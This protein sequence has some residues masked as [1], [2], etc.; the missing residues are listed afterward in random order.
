MREITLGHINCFPPI[1]VDVGEVRYLFDIWS[2]CDMMEA[3]LMGATNQTPRL[4]RV[5]DNPTNDTV[6]HG[7]CHYLG[8]LMKITG[9]V[10]IYD[11]SEFVTLVL[12]SGSVVHLPVGVKH[13]IVVIQDGDMFNVQI[14]FNQSK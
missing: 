13:S 4:T 9:V 5:F 11:N 12:Y 2:G 7:T 8:G 6:I 10:E 3:W 14:D 1:G